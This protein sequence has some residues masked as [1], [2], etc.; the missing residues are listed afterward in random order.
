[1][2]RKDIEQ[3]ITDMVTD[4]L[5]NGIAPWRKPWNGLGYSPTSLQ[6]GKPYRGVNRF[7]LSLFADSYGYE[8]PLWVTFKQAKYLGGHVRKGEHGVPVVFYSMVNK[9]NKDTGETERIPLLRL[10]NVFNIAQCDGLTIPAKFMVKAE[11]VPVLDGVAKMLDLYTSK[12]EIY[13]AGGDE[14]YY[15]PMTDTITIP[16]REQFE[17]PE[18]Y[19]YTLAHELVHSTSHES[20]L[21]RKAEQGFAPFGSA[22]Y[23]EEELVADIGAQ[24]VLSDV[25]V[26]VDIEN[27]AS[28]LRGWLKALSDDP[29]MI[30]KAS[31][32]AQK[33]A[34]YML[35]IKY[36]TEAPADEEELVGVA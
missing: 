23:A 33:A 14:A 9:R 17:K 10:S 16:R 15:R 22:T 1:M 31:S 12:P 36:E 20:R 24:M 21:N 8:R 26:S 7:T 35:G 28:Y 4:A 13:H 3:R 18:D 32:K 19:A 11:P 27:S 6:T 25:G 2:N 29:S 34:D 5:R 30:I